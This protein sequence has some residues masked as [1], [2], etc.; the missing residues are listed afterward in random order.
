M[1]TFDAQFHQFAQKHEL[2]DTPTD[3]PTKTVRLIT[4]WPKVVGVWRLDISVR[5]FG[6]GLPGT[7]LPSAGNQQRQA[8]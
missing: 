5:V 6:T 2:K 8:H 7:Y 3:T 4:I 1:C